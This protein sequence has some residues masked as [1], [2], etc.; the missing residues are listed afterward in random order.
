[1]K[2][3]ILS[4]DQGTSGTKA[5]LFDRRGQLVGRHNE[6]HRQ[7]YPR[8][9]WVEHDADEIYTRVLAAV[10]GVL[11]DTGI[12][13]D[14]VAALAISN[15]RETVV[16]WDKT[17]GRPVCNAVVWQCKRG[18]ALCAD[19]K[20]RGIADEVKRKTGLVLSPYF[21]AA[22]LAWILDH[23]DGA[24]EKAEQGKLL[25]GNMDA[26]L[27]YKLA[28]VHVTDYSNASRTQ[29]FNLNT[30]EW[31]DDLL[32]LFRIPRAV[33]PR[34][35]P[36]DS[37]FGMTDCGGIFENPIPITGVMGDSHAALFGQACFER[38]MAKAT[39]GTG[40]SVMM[41]IG[42]ERVL[43]Q[44]GLVTSIAW[45]MSGS[46]NYVFEGNINY[47]GATIKWLAD[48][49]GLIETA[50][51]A[52]TLAASV[53]GNGGVYFVPA[54]SGLGPPYWD[55]DAKAIITGLTGGSQKAH[56]LRA[57]E[58]SIAYQIRDVLDVMERDAVPLRE[59]RVDGGPTRDDFL[60]KFQADM[61][62]VTVVRNQ[63]EEISAAGAAY[64]AG[65][66]TGIW[67][68]LEEVETLRSVERSFVS[69]MPEEQRRK[70]YG[71][72]KEAVSRAVYRP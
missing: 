44:N 55:S 10:R 27:I 2:Q 3:Y 45:C 54:F 59:L 33:L 72:W 7:I 37:I 62:G 9:G 19:L 30:L 57:A 32:D 68:D 53:D 67:K 22:K 43:S 13:P 61:L 42:E 49:L 29:L 56:V 50:G 34:V 28:G 1:M 66:S 58:E 46:V 35:M 64:M 47:A 6:A 63:I 4:I 31:D 26:W 11:D 21:S 18:E 24:R 8:P 38:G 40:S 52:A 69:D 14:T 60:M 70:L 65:I 48:G 23:V 39:L 51:E 12:S 5:V 20:A 16:A 17:T 36:S 25:C 71:G 41:N 15:Q